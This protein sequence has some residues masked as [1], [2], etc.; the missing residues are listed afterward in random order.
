MPMKEK[1]SE[2]NELSL[3]GSCSA[4]ILQELE[5]QFPW[6]GLAFAIAQLKTRHKL[7]QSISVKKGLETAR[8]RGI[9]LGRP[10][11]TNYED[12]QALRSQKLTYRQIS[13]E[14]NVH[15]TTIQRALKNEIK[16]S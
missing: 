14:L 7:K 6:T 3:C 15:S 10:R 16:T 11:N 13:K 1:D 4:F 8:S 5:K 9:K 12:I 2:T